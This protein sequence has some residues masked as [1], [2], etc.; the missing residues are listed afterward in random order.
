MASNMFGFI[1]SGQLVRVD[2]QQVDA[3][4]FVFL[5]PDAGSIGHMVVFLTGAMPFGPGF[6]ATVHFG[7]PKDGA[8]SWQLLGALSNEKP[9][10]IFRVS[11][12]KSSS[13]GGSTYDGDVMMDGEGATSNFVSPSPATAVAQIGISIEPEAVVQ[14][15]MREKAAGAASKQLTRVGASEEA[16][17]MT[18]ARKLLQHFYNYVSSFMGPNTDA[19]AMRIMQDWYNT[20]ERKVKLD[21]SWVRRDTL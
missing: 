8:M 11:G 20:V 12:V 10:A 6:A 19:A 16:E 5:V 4:K 13:G 17:V 21:P 3:N 14:E 1:A 7:W 2:A 18:I 15:Q 9:S